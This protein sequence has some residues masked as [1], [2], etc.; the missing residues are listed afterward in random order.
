MSFCFNLLYCNLEFS[1]SSSSGGSTEHSQQQRPVVPD[2]SSL[3]LK[4]AQLTST[5]SSMANDVGFVNVPGNLQTTTQ[6]VIH[7][8]RII[9]LIFNIIYFIRINID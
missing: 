8:V 9:L 6:A 2:L 5:G 3:Q 7:P 1:S 4:L